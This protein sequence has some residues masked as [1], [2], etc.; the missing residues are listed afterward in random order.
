M[1]PT[2]EK[3]KQKKL[4]EGMGGGGLMVEETHSNSCTGCSASRKCRARERVSEARRSPL[5]RCSACKPPRTPLPTSLPSPPSP[6][7]PCSCR[8]FFFPCLSFHSCVSKTR[9]VIQR[10]LYVCHTARPSFWSS[11]TLMR[12]YDT[13][14]TSLVQLWPLHACVDEPKKT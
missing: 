5:T 13:W 8:P 4:T 11:A 3:T 10:P 14:C 9:E 2:T 1:E 6:A 12:K 7:F